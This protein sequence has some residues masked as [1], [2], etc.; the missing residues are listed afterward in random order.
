[1]NTYLG[2]DVSTTATKAL[3]I[4]EQGKVIGARS[5]SYP[6]ESPKPLWSEQHPDLWWQATKLSIQQVIAQTGVNPKDVKGV[7][8]TGQMHGLVLVDKDQ[9]LLR[10]SIIWCDSRAVTHG[11]HA[12]KTLG[13]EQCLSHLLNSPGNFT[14]SKLSWVIMNEPEIYEKAKDKM[15]PRAC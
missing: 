15:D 10:S 6:C 13:E 3:L 1:M 4:D 9:K 11:E 12:M 5:N 2:I 8:L 14:A 7:G